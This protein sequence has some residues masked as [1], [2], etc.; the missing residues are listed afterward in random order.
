MKDFDD[1]DNKAKELWE[2]TKDK[3][4]DMTDEAKAKYHETRGRMDEKKEQDRES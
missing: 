3:T 2:D 4:G 1:I